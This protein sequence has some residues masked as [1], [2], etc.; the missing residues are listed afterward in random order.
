MNIKNKFATKIIN[1]I[2]IFS[3]L[4]I[5]FFAGYKTGEIKTKKKP[6]YASDKINLITDNQK[7]SSQAKENIDF[8]LFWEAWNAIEELYVDK[9][10]IDPQKMYYGAIKGMV[11]SLDD[12]YTFF[13]TPEENKES[14]LDLEG[15]FEGIGAQLGMK[16]DQIVIIS[17]LKNS[18][19]EKAGIKTGDIITKVNGEST[20]GWTLTQAVNKIRGE[21]GSKVV[22]T[23][24]RNEEELEIPIIRDEIKIPSIEYQVKKAD[25][26]GLKTNQNF[27]YIK[28]IQFGTETNDEWNKTVNDVVKQLK[29]N[30]ISGIIL[31]LRNNPG[32]LLNSAIYLAED[33][34]QKGDLIVKQEFVNKNPIE[35]Y[36]E[37]NGRLYGTKLAVIV[38][39]GSASASEIL[40]GA[41][42]DHKKAVIVGEQTF[43]KGS[44]QQAIDLSGSAGMHITI[45]KWVL[46]NGK[47][48][49]DTGITPDISVTIDATQTNNQSNTETEDQQLIKAIEQLLKN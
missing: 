30:N 4:G 9:S 49:N 47:W 46:P 39:K 35:Y 18:P 19:A 20:A 3:F 43:G 33:F 48:I 7:I 25:E 22:L 36:S 27:A 2:L 1:F 17:P 21:K 23:V 41:L 12:P 11:A 24:F 29:N 37:R 42:Q 13:L 26:Y 8:S 38:N 28:I 31:D 32:G 6:S 45:S 44:V 15:K 34:L 5:I 40:A 14:K 10:K 16:N